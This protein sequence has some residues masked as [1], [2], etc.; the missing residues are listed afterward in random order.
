MTN[1]DS[2]LILRFAG[3]AALSLNPRPITMVLLACVSE[4][5]LI[6]LLFTLMQTRDKSFSDLRIVKIFIG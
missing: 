6:G 3:L 4:T 5:N 2:Y 1:C